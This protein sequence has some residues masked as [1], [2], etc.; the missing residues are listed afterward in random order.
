[1]DKLMRALTKPLSAYDES[2]I[3]GTAEL[4]KRQLWEAI[5]DPLGTRELSIKAGASFG[6]SETSPNHRMK[7][8]R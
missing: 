3:T 1:M 5:N 2:G 6:T 7:L 4:A 8:P